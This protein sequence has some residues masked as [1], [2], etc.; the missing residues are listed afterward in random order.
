MPANDEDVKVEKLKYK[1]AIIVAIVGPIIA[2]GCSVVYSRLNH[3]ES[4]QGYAV[5][6]RLVNEQSEHIG[7]LTARVDRM[8]KAVQAA[9][10][11]PTAGPRI[12]IEHYYA[13]AAAKAP[14]KAMLPLHKAPMT[15]KAAQRR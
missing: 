7:S 8:E 5:L 12:H 4:A 2:L 11:Q 9:A 3:S 14:M 6:A 13:K 15:L 1:A 10:S